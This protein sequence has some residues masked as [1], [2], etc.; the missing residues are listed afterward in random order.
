MATTNPIPEEA[1]DIEATRREVDAVVHAVRESLT[2][3]IV[4][5][6]ATTATNTLG[7]VDRLN[8]PDTADAIHT[9]I[10]RVT[11]FHRLGALDTLFESVRVIHAVREALTDNIVERG[12]T[13]FER[14]VDTVG[15]EVMLACVDDVLSALES[16]AEKSAE[17]S[18]K[19]ALTTFWLLLKP[20]SQDTLRFM[21]NFGGE[22]SKAREKSS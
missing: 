14:I 16:A 19:G 21:L 13:Y 17:D 4:E 6:F 22:F 11:E 8:D 9:I 2:D 3:N 5:R 12:F 1:A 20:E 18:G 15:S 10:D 7:V